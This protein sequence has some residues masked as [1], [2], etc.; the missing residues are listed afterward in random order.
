LQAQRETNLTTARNRISKVL[1]EAVVAVNKSPAYEKLKPILNALEARDRFMLAKRPPP[2]PTEEIAGVAV[3]L[4]VPDAASRSYTTMSLI[5]SQYKQFCDSYVE[6]D[7]PP[8]P[9]ETLA[10]WQRLAA[11][12]PQ[13]AKVAIRHCVRATNSCGAERNFSLLT[14]MGA[15]DR[16]SMQRQTLHN[17]LFLR[18]NSWIVAD[19][20]SELADSRIAPQ[21]GSS[22]QRAEAKRKLDAAVTES[23]A[24]LNRSVKQ[25]REA[26]TVAEAAAAAAAEPVDDDDEQPLSDG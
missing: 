17:T 16:M 3:F 18:C 1:K 26:R 22:A 8:T 14:K 25:R 15:S 10:T 19:M 21:V 13:L 23:M 2:L 20:Q 4:G 11:T 5:I 9:M 24:E 6:P 12:A 7:A